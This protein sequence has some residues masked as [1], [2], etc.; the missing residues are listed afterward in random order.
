[1]EDEGAAAWKLVATLD[2]ARSA[3]THFADVDVRAALQAVIE[4]LAAV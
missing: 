1:V 2:D 4:R 3:V